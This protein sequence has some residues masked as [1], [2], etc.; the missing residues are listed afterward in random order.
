MSAVFA[1]ERDVHELLTGPAAEDLL[2]AALQPDGVELTGWQVHDIH[3]RPR[4]GVTVG[5]T[6]EYARP[7][8]STW[9]DYLCLSTARLTEQAQ[10]RGGFVTMTNGARVVHAWRHPHDP[11]LPGLPVACDA[12]GVAR[13]LAEHGVL[14][15]AD[16]PV[17]L[18]LLSYRP[19]RRAVLRA[20]SAA[21]T[22]YIKAFRPAVA[23]TVQERHQMLREA[24]LPVPEPLGR[25]ADGVL[26]LAELQGR[27]LS[28]ALAA[29]GAARL[30]PP[31]LVDVL[32]R[33]PTEL[34]R[35]RR[36]PAWA[37]RADHYGEAAAA[38]LPDQVERIARTVHRIGAAL[39]ATDAGPVVPTHGDF[40]EAQL[41]SDG[42]AIT[43]LLDVD[44]AGPG[45][46]VDDLACLLGHLSVLPSLAPAVYQHVPRTLERWLAT[47]DELVDPAALRARAAGVVLSLVAGAREVGRVGW[48]HTAMERLDVAERWLDSAENRIG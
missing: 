5:Y 30:D 3:H 16:E 1:E 33:L 42:T 6:V 14:G 29:D 4:A 24:G 22:V 35:Q 2:R 46:R 36:R 40:Y 45:H 25:S 19:T 13:L 39:A 18:E 31:L 21:R 38:V 8:G 15:S 28:A 26:L 43:G 10:R 27:P 17:Q 23:V 32:D 37:E 11:E 34:V 44:T 20:R 41:M 47:F 7:D 48:E 9:Q 12:V